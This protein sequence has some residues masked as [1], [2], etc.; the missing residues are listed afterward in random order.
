MTMSRQEA[1]KTLH[2]YLAL[3][4]DDCLESHSFS[5]RV[6][7]LQY[8]R[9]V[10]A[11]TQSLTMYFDLNPSTDPRAH[12]LLLPQIRFVFPV[13]N[14]RMLDMQDKMGD[15]P[16]LDDVNGLTLNHQ[17]FNAAPREVR[18]GTWWYI[19]DNDSA[20]ACLTA[21]LDF[22][23]RWSF[24]FLNKYTTIAALTEGFEQQDECLP[25]NR[26]FLLFIVSA[27]TLLDQPAKAMKLLESK[28]G[29]PGPRRQYAKAFK[30][31]GNL[32]N[33]E[34]GKEM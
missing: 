3:N 32:L 13:L 9:L 29:R 10:D 30:Y 21:I 19:Y 17:I 25:H 15:T 22:A 1:T 8:T 7:S 14:Q 27:Y 33:G 12:M 11:G 4:F 34:K 28:F 31:V 20:S 26:R 6:N 18:A 16:I 5:R 23:Q 2:S 24:P